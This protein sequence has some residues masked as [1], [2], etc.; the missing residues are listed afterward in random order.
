M[1][2]T[3]LP[4]DPYITAVDTILTTSGIGCDDGWTSDVDEYE[5]DGIH[6]TLSALYRWNAG[7]TALNPDE[8]PD[9]LLLLWNA[10]AGWE[11]ASLRPDGSNEIPTDLPIPVWA[12]PIDVAT[13]IRAVMGGEKPATTEQVWDNADV[14]AAVEAWRATE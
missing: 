13:R 8:H 4:H 12:A 3:A 1:P 6:T 2:R 7:D 5:P 14:P 11:Y 10:V 9:G